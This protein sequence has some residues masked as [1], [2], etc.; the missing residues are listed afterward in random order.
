MLFACGVSERSPSDVK[1]LAALHVPVP[2][3]HLSPFFFAKRSRFTSSYTHAEYGGQSP[4]RAYG[5]R[6]PTG[7]DG[8]A[9]PMAVTPAVMR[10]AR[11]FDEVRNPAG[12][13]LR[14]RGVKRQLGVRGRRAVAFRFIVFCAFRGQ[15]LLENRR[16]KTRRHTSCDLLAESRSQPAVVVRSFTAVTS[17]LGSRWPL[18]DVRR[19]PRATYSLEADC[20][21]WDA[22]PSCPSGSRRAP[23]LADGREAAAGERVGHD[24]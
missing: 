8:V 4:E 7:T 10:S 1:D 20:W 22:G 12:N 14:S 15:S 17:T 5:S 24:S 23:H 9:I 2:V 11:A 19:L 18:L 21:G 13:T 3:L 6:R 16:S